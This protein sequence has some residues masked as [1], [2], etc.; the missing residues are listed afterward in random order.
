MKRFLF[1]SICFFPFFTEAQDFVGTRPLGMGEAVR[2]TLMLNDA[3]YINPAAMAMTKQYSIDAQTVFQPTLDQ[4]LG[5][6]FSLVDT[7]ESAVGAGLGYYGNQVKT[8]EQTYWRHLVHLAL[9]QPISKFFSF[10]ATA[11]AG[12]FDEKPKSKTYLNGDIGIYVVP[13]DYGKFIQFGGVLYNFARDIKE[14]PR[15]L[16][17]GA[18][19]I[20]MPSL[21]LTGDVVKALSEEKWF[22]GTGAEF[23]HKSGISARAGF[24]Y[25][26]DPVEDSASYSAGLGYFVNQAGAY[27]SFRNRIDNKYQTHA[28]SLSL[29]F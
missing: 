27:Y 28:L 9:A 3:I 8:T 26:K 16:G 7:R 15:Q 18:K 12:F 14:F 4:D 24:K 25:D 19:V 17:G 20:L 5:I 6:N 2:G 11:K 10:G 1:I 21:S 29:F 23:L 22:F 13:G